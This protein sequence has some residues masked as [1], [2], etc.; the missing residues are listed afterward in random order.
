MYIMT[1]DNYLQIPAEQYFVIVIML[2]KISTPSRY[3]YNRI[4]FGQYFPFAINDKC[5]ESS[6]STYNIF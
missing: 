4:K 1:I 2:Y 5:L 3:F 6:I